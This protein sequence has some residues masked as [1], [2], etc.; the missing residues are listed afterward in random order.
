MES[1][2]DYYRL[3]NANLMIR[4]CPDLTWSEIRPPD[5]VQPLPAISLSHHLH[6]ELFPVNPY[7]AIGCAQVDN[8]PAVIHKLLSMHINVYGKIWRVYVLV[9][10]GIEELCGV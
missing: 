10:G 5:T 9:S 7:S 2:H 3:E 8:L 6:L 1:T 4:T